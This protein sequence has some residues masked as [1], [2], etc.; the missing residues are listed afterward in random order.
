MREVR[1]SADRFLTV[2]DGTVTRHSFSYGAHYDPANVR[3]GPLVAINVEH[4]APG[5]GYPAHRHSDV[6]IITWVLEGVLRHEDSTGIA[7]DVG[8]GVLQRLSAGPGVQHTEVN[9]SAT[10]PLVFVQMMLASDHDGD[11]EIEQR[12]V[13]PS[14]DASSSWICGIPDV[15]ITA[16]RG[17][18]W[19]ACD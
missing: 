18:V 12:A 9:A 4:L 2:G 6:E 19:R 3:F 7:G 1:R 13:E 14:P 5:S 16:R 8:P 10:D 11:P 15:A 17:G